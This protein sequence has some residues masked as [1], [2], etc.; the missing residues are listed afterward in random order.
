NEEILI[1]DY[2]STAEK[3]IGDYMTRF[4]G[5]KAGDLDINN[6]SN[7][8]HVTDIKNTYLK[9]RYLLDVKKVKFIGHGLPNDFKIIN[10]FVPKEQIIDT[11]E[12]YRLPNQRKISLRFLCKYLLN[13]DIQQDTHDSIEDARTALRLYKKYLEL[14]QKNTF[15]STL[16]DIYTLGRQ[17]NWV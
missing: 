1:D 6:K 2:I 17:T 9:L 10:I 3:R 7:T 12:L 8:H 16:Q 14:K 11:V 15:T 4:S 13:Q 5:L